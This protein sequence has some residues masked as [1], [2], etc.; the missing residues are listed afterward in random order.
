MR[1]LSGVTLR[2]SIALAGLALVLS[3]LFKLSGFA[4]EAF[5]TSRFGLSSVTDAYFV[6]QQFPLMVAAFMFGPFARVFAPAYA[7]A[8]NKDGH[9]EWC[10]GLILYAVLI[11]LVFTGLTVG[12][13]PLILGTFTASN[14]WATLEILSVCY[15]PIVFIGFRAA[16][17]TSYGNILL[18]LAVA[19]VP[20]LLM[21]LVLIGMYFAGSMGNLSLPISMSAG[22][23]VVGMM[24]LIGFLWT[25]R[26]FRKARYLFRPWRFLAFRS[27]NRQL[28]A[29][30]IE[31][32]GFSA[33]QFVMLYFMAHQGTGMIS[34]NNC[35]TRI[36]MSAYSLFSLPVAQLL[37]A[38]LCSSAR[39]E[40]HQ[41]TR[42]YTTTLAVGASLLAAVL[43]VFRYHLVSRVYMRGNFSVL[44]LEGVVSL[45]PAWLCYFVVLSL[46]GLI[47]QDMFHRSKGHLYTR[48]MLIGYFGTNVLRFAIG[49]RMG[50]SWIIWCAVI[51]EGGAFLANLLT[52]VDRFTVFGRTEPCTLG[53]SLD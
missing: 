32:F 9:V 25:E 47:S 43:Y 10:G 34:A 46:N 18:S 44:A 49:H 8:R 36:A 42:R 48:N 28:I 52:P 17:W 35:A 6:L 41:L 33:N 40:E 15:C 30:S 53:R 50:T 23:V 31:T 13:A 19:G 29:S 1:K 24:S 20:Y 16:T 14:S 37:Q 12:F 45:L 11:A 38:R 4:R 39:G 2:D 27:F 7:D 5:I 22:F 26:P 51:G 21:T 3:A